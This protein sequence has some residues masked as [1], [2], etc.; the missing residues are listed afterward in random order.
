M[1]ISLGSIVFG[2]GADTA[3]L[4]RSIS[5][6]RAFGSAVEA[7]AAS[8]NTAGTQ[9]ETAFRRQEAAMIKALQQVQ[10][11]Q[12]QVSRIKAPQVQSGLNQ[13]SSSALAQFTARMSSGQLSAIQF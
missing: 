9:V 2:L 3:S 6:I 7:A 1:P 11:Y 10:K 5:D 8:A 4:G 12:D 13:L